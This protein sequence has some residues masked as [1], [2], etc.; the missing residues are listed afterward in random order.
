MGTF[1]AYFP[2][3]ATLP[4]AQPPPQKRPRLDRRF[5]PTIAQR[6]KFESLRDLATE[7]GVSYETIRAVVRRVADER[8]SFAAD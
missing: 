2:I 1:P 5:Y 4:V 6:A 3:G 7:Y 8:R